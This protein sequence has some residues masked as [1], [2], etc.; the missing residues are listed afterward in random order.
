MA[1]SSALFELGRTLGRFEANVAALDPATAEVAALRHVADVWRVYCRDSGP[2]HVGPAHEPSLARADILDTDDI[3]RRNALLTWLRIHA[4]GSVASAAKRIAIMVDAV[5]VFD[6]PDRALLAHAEDALDTVPHAALMTPAALI[7]LVTRLRADPQFAE[8]RGETATRMVGG[9]AVSHFV[10]AEPGGGWSLNVALAA[11]RMAPTGLFA[12][13]LFRRDLE[14]DEIEGLVLDQLVIS[15]DSASRRLAALER[16]L[17]RGFKA[18]G[19]RRTN[20]RAMDAW[21][22]HVAFG[23]VRRAHLQRALGLSR[24]GA[25]LQLAELGALGLTCSSANSLTG[26]RS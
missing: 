20:S 6:E 16:A 13:A 26:N 19:P 12:R 22:L 7:S 15:I 24:A 2:G 25:A 9:R 17:T 5:G 23:R 11:R 3:T 18:L 1:Q 8:G 10:A 14:P 4:H 21:G